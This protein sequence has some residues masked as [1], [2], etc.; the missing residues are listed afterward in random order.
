MRRTNRYFDS[1]GRTLFDRDVDLGSVSVPEA[2]PTSDSDGYPLGYTAR[3]GGA[4]FAPYVI[5]LADLAGGTDPTVDFN[6]YLYFHEAQDFANQWQLIRVATVTDDVA[7]G[8]SFVLLPTLGA[9][10]YDARVRT[11]TGSPTRV[12]MH[13]RA[14]N[15]DQARIL[16]M[17]D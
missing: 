10:R 3:P 4:A 15:D 6:L 8:P 17:S 1:Q 9:Q 14:I 5:L 13:A 11:T 16:G 2:G 7:N 12:Y